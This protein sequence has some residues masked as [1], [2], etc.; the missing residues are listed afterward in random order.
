MRV[1][2]VILLSLLVFSFQNC[3]SQSTTFVL[4]PSQSM[5]MTGKGPGQDGAINPYAGTDSQA[6][7]QNIGPGPFQIRV[8]K[9]GEIL[10]TL[11]IK[12][13]ETKTVKLLNG[14]ELYFDTEVKTSVKLEFKKL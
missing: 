8:Q 1:K 5:L 4:E 10:E 11:P 13:G 2:I 3:T 14:Y 7:I 12:P 6:L 9:Q